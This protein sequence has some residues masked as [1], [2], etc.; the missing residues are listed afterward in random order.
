MGSPD[1][2]PAATRAPEG[3]VDAAVLGKALAADTYACSALAAARRLP[4]AGQD[5]RR[6]LLELESHFRELERIGATATALVHRELQAMSL[7]ACPHRFANG[8]RCQLPP[9]HEG[10][11]GATWKGQGGFWC[12]S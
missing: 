8:V 5:R 9:G 4:A 10:Q 7:S 2:S 3:G 11:H 1:L 12:R 6:F